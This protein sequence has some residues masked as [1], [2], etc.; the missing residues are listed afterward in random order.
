M[1]KQPKPEPEPEE[2]ISVD[3]PQISKLDIDIDVYGSKIRFGDIVGTKGQGFTRDVPSNSERDSM[4][5][6]FFKEAGG[7]EAPKNPE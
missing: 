3:L 6:D 5:S 7:I 2:E 1:G 4:R